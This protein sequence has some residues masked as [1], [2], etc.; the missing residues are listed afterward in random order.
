M[1]HAVR[2]ADRHDVATTVAFLNFPTVP[3]THTA[4]TEMLT[5]CAT[6]NPP[7]CGGKCSQLLPQ[8]CGRRSAAGGRSTSKP[9]SYFVRK[10]LQQQHNCAVMRT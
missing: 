9:N 7:Q 8:N 10:I 2:Q 1:F 6:Q 4:L 3:K 5:T